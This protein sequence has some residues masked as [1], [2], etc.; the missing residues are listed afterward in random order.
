M[1]KLK[2]EESVRFFIH[3]M[4]ARYDDV[5]KADDVQKKWLLMKET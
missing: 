5:T 1:W 4:A 2:E 3:E